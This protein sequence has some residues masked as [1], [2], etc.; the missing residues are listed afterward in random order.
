MGCLA[1]QVQI[2]FVETLFEKISV[3]ASARIQ[4][5]AKPTVLTM[6]NE[7]AWIAPGIVPIT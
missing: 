6:L 4:G 3:G 1:Q 7:P 2:A 5:T